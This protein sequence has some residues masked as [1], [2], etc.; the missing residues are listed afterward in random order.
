MGA[1]SSARYLHEAC[2]LIAQLIYQI[3]NPVEH[4]MDDSTGPE[5]RRGRVYRAR[6]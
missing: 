1:E 4:R 2:V 3:K 6:G 5:Q